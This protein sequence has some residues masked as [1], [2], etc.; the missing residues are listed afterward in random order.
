MP[1]QISLDHA[2]CQPKEAGFG[3]GGSCSATRA[4]TTPWAKRKASRAHVEDLRNPRQASM[5]AGKPA[6]K[7]LRSTEKGKQP[8]TD[9]EEKRNLL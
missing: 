1:Q 5:K 9:Q 2:I 4:E 6:G 8:S 3:D 7:Q